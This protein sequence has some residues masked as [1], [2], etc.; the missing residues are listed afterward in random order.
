MG[1]GHLSEN[2]LAD[3]KA[4]GW[5]GPP[6]AGPAAVRGQPALP[7][8]PA[9]HP[10]APKHA[11]FL[12]FGHFTLSGGQGLGGERVTGTFGEHDRNFS[13][14][15]NNLCSITKLYCRL[16]EQRLNYCF[17]HP[18]SVVPGEKPDCHDFL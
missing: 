10:G 4:R 11:L 16:L 3:P 8:R 13:L 18:N 17:L 9:A 14:G 1:R 6:P 5:A 15:R 12:R 2:P 7:G